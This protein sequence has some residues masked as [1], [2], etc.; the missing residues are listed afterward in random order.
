MTITRDIGNFGMKNAIPT[1]GISL[2]H[3]NKSDRQMLIFS[4]KGVITYTYFTKSHKKITRLIFFLIKTVIYL[5]VTYVCK[6]I[7]IS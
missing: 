2:Y 3:S 7:E 6:M 4:I 1:C 5:P